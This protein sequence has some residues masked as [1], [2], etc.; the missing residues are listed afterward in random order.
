MGG[1]CVCACAREAAAGQPAGGRGGRSCDRCDIYEA[2]VKR[3]TRRDGAG[4]TC[5]DASEEMRMRGTN[6][7]A[8]RDMFLASRE[9]WVYHWIV[10]LEAGGSALLLGD[11]CSISA[12]QS[13]KTVADA[14]RQ[15]HWSYDIALRRG[16][17]TH[18]RW[19][20]SLRWSR[21]T[22]RGSVWR[23]AGLLPRAPVWV[24]REEGYSRLD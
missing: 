19:Y 21:P 3:K 24:C 23:A 22:P 18:K 20:L 6:D 14:G 15:P 13:S 8:G 16:E 17:S 9:A 1:M 4:E 10:H 2:C 7:D 5:D 11:A 12:R